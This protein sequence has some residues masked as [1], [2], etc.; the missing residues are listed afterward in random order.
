M[1]EPEIRHGR[2]NSSSDREKLQ[3]KLSSLR[4][5]V[6]TLCK[7]L[8]DGR[9]PQGKHIWSIPVDVHRDFDCR[10]LDAIEELES[11]RAAMHEKKMASVWDNYPWE[12][13]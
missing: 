8:W 3:R 12:Q 7:T 4:C 13:D 2:G 6:S 1:G 5:T 11:R 10:L 9:V